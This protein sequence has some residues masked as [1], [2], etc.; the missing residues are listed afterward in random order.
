MS[1]IRLHI[2]K[3]YSDIRLCFRG[4]EAIILVSTIICLYVVMFIRMYNII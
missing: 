2:Y 1:T 4:N 3:C